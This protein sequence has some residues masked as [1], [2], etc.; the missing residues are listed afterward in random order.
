MT[1]SSEVMLQWLQNA[2]RLIEQN[3]DVL[4]ELDAAIG[5]ADHG[6]NMD[7]GF[8]KVLE[9]VPALKGKDAGSILKAA[10]MALIANVGGAAGPLYGT[11]FLRAGEAVAGKSQLEPGDFSLLL[12]QGVDGV[13]ARGRASLGAKTMVDALS[14]AV[15][16]LELAFRKGKNPGEAMGAALAAGE[17]GMRDTIPMIATKGR[18]SYLGPRSAGHQDPGATSSVLL[19]RA[20]AEALPRE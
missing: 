5:D 10:G 13:L 7:R 4:T 20:L 19:L 3:R 17:K 16:A 14:P 18:A 11:F 8:R 9:Q 6:I 2:A 12:R 1:L 15:A